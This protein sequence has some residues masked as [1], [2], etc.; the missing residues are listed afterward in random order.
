[1][2]KALA[3]LALVLFMGGF[4]VTAVAATIDSKATIELAEEEKKSEKKSESKDC[5]ATKESTAKS[6]DCSKECE[7]KCEGE[8][9]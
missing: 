8:K 9:K 3:I 1:M 2:K 7:K 4:S 5:E 6:S